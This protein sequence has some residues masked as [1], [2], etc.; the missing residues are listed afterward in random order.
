MSTPTEAIAQVLQDHSYVDYGRA[1]GHDDWR[2]WTK[3]GEPNGCWEEH[4]AAVVV[5]ALTANGWAPLED[6]RAIIARGL[7]SWNRSGGYYYALRDALNFIDAAAVSPT[8][9]EQP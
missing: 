2:A 4:V 8:Q 9:K 1:C 5:A 3:D 7:E 6:L